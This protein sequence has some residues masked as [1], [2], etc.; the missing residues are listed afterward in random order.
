M[1]ENLKLGGVTYR[2]CVL[3]HNNHYYLMDAFYM[4]EALLSTEATQWKRFSP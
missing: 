3:L 1:W 4:S 2:L